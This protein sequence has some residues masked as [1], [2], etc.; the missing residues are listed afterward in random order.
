MR[1]VVQFGGQRRVVARADRDLGA[2]GDAGER[3]AA[4]RIL[5]HDALRLV[6]VGLYR[7]AFDRAKM[8][9]PKLV[10]GGQRGHQHVFRVPA[11]RVAAKRR[12]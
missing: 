3:A 2:Q 5:G 12:V 6:P 1:A 4:C 10:A 9:I 11:R 8:Q 7:N